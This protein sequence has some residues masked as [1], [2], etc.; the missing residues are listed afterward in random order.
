MTEEAHALE[1]LLSSS[2]TPLLDLCRAQAHRDMIAA[3]NVRD[4]VKLVETY[5][6]DKMGDFCYGDIG[7]YTAE[8]EIRARKMSEQYGLGGCAKK[9]TRAGHDDE[10]DSC[11]DPA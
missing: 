5:L 6:R 7:V 8:R 10:D 2:D 9:R 4:Y 1:E 11:Y 3:A